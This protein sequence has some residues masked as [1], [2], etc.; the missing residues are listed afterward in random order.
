MK[1]V[2]LF[3]AMFLAGNSFA[4]WLLVSN[5]TKDIV[6]ISNVP[7]A[8]EG[9]TSLQISTTT[10]SEFEFRGTSVASFYLTGEKLNGK[11]LRWGFFNEEIK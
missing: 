10:I 11:K 3:C 2:I 1:T 6:A 7:I 9:H 5:T 8:L 4:F